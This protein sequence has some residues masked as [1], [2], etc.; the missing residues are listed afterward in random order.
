MENWENMCLGPQAGM[1]FAYG[2]AKALFLSN[3]F[4]LKKRKKG[5]GKKKEPQRVFLWMTLYI[6]FVT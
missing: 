6:E 2:I 5:G 1:L 3:G 4:K